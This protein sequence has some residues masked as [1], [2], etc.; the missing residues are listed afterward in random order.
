MHKLY[1]TSLSHVA[2]PVL[3]VYIKFTHFPLFSFK[4]I[5]VSWYVIMFLLC[6]H[7]IKINVAFF[8]D[9]FDKQVYSSVSITVLYVDSDM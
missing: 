8:A 2:I 7:K 6:T 9:N 1:T 5:P 3:N 4:N